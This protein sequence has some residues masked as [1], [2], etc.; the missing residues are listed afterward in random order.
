MAKIETD[1][2]I[3]TYKVFVVKIEGGHTAEA[4]AEAEDYESSIDSDDE[5]QKILYSGACSISP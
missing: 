3:I 4:E 5:M 1:C 2:K